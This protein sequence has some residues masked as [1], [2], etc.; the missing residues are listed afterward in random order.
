MWDIT[1]EVYKQM[2]PEE[3]F[4]SANKRFQGFRAGYG[5]ILF[6]EETDTIRTFQEKFK[7]Y[8]DKFPGW[9][10][11]TN[12]MHQYVIWTALEAEGLGVNLQHYNPLIDVRLATEYKL[13]TTWDLKAQMVFGK[14]TSGPAVENKEF[15]PIEE[16][17]KVHGAQ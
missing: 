5:T 7:T 3:K 6:Y 2:L 11:Q 1:S 13:P 8:Q 15:L 14:P 10:E 12:G 4:N 17:M 16:R 9:S